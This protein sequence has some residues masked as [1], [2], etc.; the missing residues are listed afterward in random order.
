MYNIKLILY[1]KVMNKDF[2]YLSRYLVE[3]KNFDNLF[4]KEHWESRTSMQPPTSS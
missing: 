3:T 4:V 2:K 1:A